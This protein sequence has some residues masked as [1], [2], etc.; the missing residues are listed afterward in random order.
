MGWSL[1]VGLLGFDKQST[2]IGTV[3]IAEC[4]MQFHTNRNLITVQVTSFIQM[5]EISLG[6]VLG[7]APPRWRL[8]LRR[9]EDA[10]PYHVKRQVC[11]FQWA[12]R[13]EGISLE[14]GRAE[15]SGTSKTSGAWQRRACAP[16]HRPARSKC[17]RTTDFSASA[18]ETS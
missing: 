16:R 8:S 14:G 9:V 12:G 7:H 4:F 15:T 5:H 6:N 11:R 17:Y 1:W 18:A 3:E 2:A 13:P 10:P